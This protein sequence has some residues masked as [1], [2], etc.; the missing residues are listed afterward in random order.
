MLTTIQKVIFLQ[1]I[2]IFKHTATE[3]LAHIAAITD[4]IK[5][6]ANQKLYS[7]GEMS[8]SMYIVVEGEIRLHANGTEITRARAKDAIGTWALLDDEPRVMTA[9]TLV[10]SH[11][12]RIDKDDFYD[13][14]ADHVQIAQGIFKTLVKDIRGLAAR[15][16]GGLPGVKKPSE[17]QA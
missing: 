15:V 2:E 7:E 9:T 12:L 1:E 17:E 10:D 6:E 8:D 11:L 4:E 3:D 16:G 13:L 5:L 14:L